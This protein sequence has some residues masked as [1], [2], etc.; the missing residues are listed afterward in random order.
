MARSAGLV[1]CWLGGTCWYVTFS[2][3]KYADSEAEVSLSRI[4]WE[5][6]KDLD[7]K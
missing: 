4:K 6:G 5:M 2:E 7:E 1:R 3:T